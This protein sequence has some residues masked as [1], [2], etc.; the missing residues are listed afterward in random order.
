M[1]FHNKIWW[2]RL[3][4]QCKTK[5]QKSQ[6]SEHGHGVYMPQSNQNGTRNC[7]S[8]N[9][10][11]SIDPYVRQKGTKTKD[12]QILN[13]FLVWCWCWI[14]IQ[15]PLA[16]S[17]TSDQRL[18]TR[19]TG[20]SWRMG[21]GGSVCGLSDP[22]CPN[23]DLGGVGLCWSGLQYRGRW[24]MEGGQ[25]RFGVPRSLGTLARTRELWQT[26]DAPRAHALTRS[27]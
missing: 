5:V 11:T 25:I 4:L 22:F 9:K 15:C 7:M 10:V 21:S 17:L 12:I 1:D 3:L 2:E 19:S 14:L 23:C 20:I 6:Q 16:L 8:Q 27:P 26:N 24:Q 13:V 18:K